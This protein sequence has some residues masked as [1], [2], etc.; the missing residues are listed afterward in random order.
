MER[1][2]KQL[3]AVVLLAAVGVAAVAQIPSPPRDPV[4]AGGHHMERMRSFD[5]EKMQARRAERLARLKQQ[6]QITPAQEAAWNAWTEAMLPTG[7][8]KRRGRAE[9]EGLT[10]PE[11]IERMRAL[12]AER[13][14][15]MDE[16]ADATLT[17]Y[18]VL[19][20]EQKRTFDEVA[21]RRGGHRHGRHHRHQ[22]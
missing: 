14:A 22:D 21:S 5:P 15:R 17:F 10:T 16:R 19:S 20:A 7:D 3:I 2:L 12:R 8:M 6:L 18:A 9:L 1:S 13:M 4:V 11:R